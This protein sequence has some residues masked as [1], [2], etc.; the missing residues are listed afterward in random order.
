MPPGTHTKQNTFNLHRLPLAAIMATV[1]ILGTGCMAPTRERNTAAVL[2]QVESEGVLFDCGEGTQR[3]MKLAGIPLPK[4]THILLTHWHGDHIFGL[5]GLL[6]S[7]AA[8]EYSRTLLIFGPEGTKSSYEKMVRLFGLSTELKVEVHDVSPGEFHKNRFFTLAAEG[9][10]HEIPC[11]G[12]SLTLPDKRR[13]N[14]EYAKEA[15]LK[16]GPLMGKLQNNEE[17]TFNGKKI[18][19]KQATYLV[20]GTKLVYLTDTLYCNGAVRI[21]EDADVLISEATFTTDLEEKADSYKHLTAR[22]AAKIANQA[23]AK[24]LILTHFSQRF[25]NTQPLEEEA[26][27]IFN[28]VVSAKDFMHFT[29]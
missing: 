28:N 1:T 20:K 26:R 2:A 19:P 10:E 29:L 23:N 3:Q 16:P 9:L 11:L 13:I 17:V 15:G 8:S 18:T 6:Q 14:L 21:A 27:D 12:Y 7:L 4:V 5:P 22:D 24:K 25:S